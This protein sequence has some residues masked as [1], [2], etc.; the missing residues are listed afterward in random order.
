MLLKYRSNDKEYL[1]N[2][3]IETILTNRTIELFNFSL[4]G[5]RYNQT[6]TWKPVLNTPHTVMSQ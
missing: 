3:H 2:S 5:K 4:F 6:N 1:D